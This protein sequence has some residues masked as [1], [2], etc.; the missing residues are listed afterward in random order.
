[1]HRTFGLCGPP[2]L[3]AEGRPDP[4]HRRAAQKGAHLRFLVIKRLRIRAEFAVA[5]FVPLWKVLAPRTQVYPSILAR[6]NLCSDSMHSL[7]SGSLATADQ[8]GLL[9]SFSEPQ[10]CSFQGHVAQTRELKGF[11]RTAPQYSQSNIKQA[12]RESLKLCLVD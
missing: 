11:G 6:Y 9:R 8:E 3:R 2:Q 12:N 10:R 7:L 4:G 5:N 1:M